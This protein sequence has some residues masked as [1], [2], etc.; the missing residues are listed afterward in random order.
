MAD[1][2]PF[3]TAH[4]IPT[5]QGLPFYTQRVT[6]DGRDYNLRFAWN[7]RL[8]R[9]YLDIRDGADVS[10]LVGLKLV[11]NWPL[12]LAYHHDE[13]LPA[14][15]LVVMTSLPDNSPPGYMDLGVG[16]RCE[17]TYLSYQ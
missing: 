12:L 4:K 3:V 11:T 1:P 2:R 7:Q 9:W 5:Q 14:G 13:R 8:E 17:L 10:L 15:E 16:L 6:L